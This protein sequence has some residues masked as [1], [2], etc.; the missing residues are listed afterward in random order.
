MRRRALILTAA[1]AAACAE[2][3]EAGD[4]GWIVGTWTMTEVTMVTG[5]RWTLVVAR[6]EPDGR[7]AAEWTSG[8]RL[9][10]ASVRVDGDRVLVLAPGGEQATLRRTAEGR[11]DGVVR[12][13]GVNANSFPV[14][15]LRR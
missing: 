10:F 11:L 9:S 12:P 14:T 4:P 7:A 5:G 3:E 8:T 6:I 2:R 13:A 15:L 1:A